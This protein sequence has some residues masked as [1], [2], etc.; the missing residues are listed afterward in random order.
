VQ[1]P[2][3]YSKLTIPNDPAYTA[4]A[5]IYVRQV[6]DKFGFETS[7]LELIVK[8]VIEAVTN[9]ILHAFEPTEK[10][11]VEIACE[12]VPLGL[13]ITV[14]D[15]GLP[16]DPAQVPEC[17]FPEQA[18]KSYVPGCG[19]FVMKE[20]MDEVYFNNLGHD[21]KE[22]VL[23]KYLKS[24]DL[25][26]YYKACDLEPYGNAASIDSAITD[27]IEFEVRPLRFSEA[28]EV[29]RCVYR[30]YGYSYSNEIAY[31]PDRI[32]QLIESGKI[33][34]AV[35]VTK[36]GEI[37]G[38]CALLM[39]DDESR[40]AEMGMGAV[41]PVFRG[42]GVFKRLSEYLMEK[43]PSFGLMGVFARA[44]TNH[45]YSQQVAHGLGMRDCALFV[46]FVPRSASFKGITEE[47]Q[48]R[49]SLVT[50]FR[51]LQKA[52]R[53]VLY[54]PQQHR[55][56]I[57][58]LYANIGASVE[59]RAAGDSDDL[60]LPKESVI[61]ARTYGKLSIAE[62]D[63]EVYGQD[64]VAQ[65]RARLKDLCMKHVDIIYLYL[66]M[67][68]PWTARFGGHFEEMGFFF[69]GILPGSL[70]GDALILQYLNNVP[71]DY[72]KIK[73]ESSAGKDMLAYIREHDPNANA[74]SKK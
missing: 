52:P 51:Y 14:R 6:A 9:V 27:E 57:G 39:W 47:L 41:K 53:E 7:D 19:L 13:K 72:D 63:V 32:I 37:A 50:H 33:F 64:V 16:F 20:V 3:E 28:V 46:G 71:I 45:T 21:G 42:Y 36:Q 11:S 1:D 70:P 31:Y 73:L 25:T 4:I 18:R 8:S 59:L 23:I 22:T 38:H 43:A 56:I 29:S 15:K 67:S 74:L 10:A 66:D 69:A 34:S 35:A 65:V 44:V 58:W 24:R 49:D 12:R 17:P 40:V 62:I 48:Q 2:C 54:S 68:D 5:S 61:K 30:S 55:D 60:D 26:D